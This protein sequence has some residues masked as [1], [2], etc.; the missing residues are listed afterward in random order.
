VFLGPLVA[1]CVLAACGGSGRPPRLD[2][3]AFAVADSYTRLA[4]NE[5]DC[6]AAD[7]Y[8]YRSF[9]SLCRGGLSAADSFRLASGHITQKCGSYSSSSS[10]SRVSP[11]CIVYTATN[12]DT[13]TYFMTKTQDGWRIV[14]LGTAGNMSGP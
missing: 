12:G 7:R 10:G 2:R 3:G 11:G 5:H 4:F 1:A 14:Y 9:G 6:R 13:V 8:G